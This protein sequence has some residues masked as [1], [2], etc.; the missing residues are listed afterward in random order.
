[1]RKSIFVRLLITAFFVSTLN[2]LT[3]CSVHVHERHVHKHKH[4][5]VPPGH[6]K[7]MHGSKSAKNYTKKRR[8]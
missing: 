6:A 4:K 2:S 7:K 1:M 3:G 8:G 5:R